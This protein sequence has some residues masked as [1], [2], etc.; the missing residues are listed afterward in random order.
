MCEDVINVN[1]TQPDMSPKKK[2]LLEDYGFKS[3]S[4][5]YYEIQHLTIIEVSKVARQGVI[6]WSLICSL[7]INHYWPADYHS[8]PQIM[9]GLVS[10]TPLELK[11]YLLPKYE[12]TL[13]V[14]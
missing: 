5:E 13:L 11:L 2:E 14:R 1:L 4:M 10:I 12:L 7:Q 9:A 8:L 6:V 3:D